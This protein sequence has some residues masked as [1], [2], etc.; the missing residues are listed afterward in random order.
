[1]SMKKLLFVIA[2]SI[3]AEEPKKLTSED[4][5]ALSLLSNKVLN[6]RLDLSEKQRVYNVLIQELPK[7]VAEKKILEDNLNIKIEEL[8][9]KYN[10]KG[11]CSISEDIE[12]ICVEEIKKEEK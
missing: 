9:K 6:I 10:H 4:Q 5:L 7:K 8:R 1:M 3:F 11:K 12:L 2:L